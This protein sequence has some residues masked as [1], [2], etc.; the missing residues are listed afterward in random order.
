[1]LGLRIKKTAVQQKMCS[2]AHL[3]CTIITKEQ[4]CLQGLGYSCIIFSFQFS[5]F[6]KRKKKLT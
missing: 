4:Q 3:F 1:M 6:K 5:I 2:T